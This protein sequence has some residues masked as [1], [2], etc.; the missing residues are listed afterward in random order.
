MI[1]RGDERIWRQNNCVNDRGMLNA[2]HLKSLFARLVSDAVAELGYGGYAIIGNIFGRGGEG[3]KCT[4]TCEFWRTC[5]GRAGP[6]ISF[7][8]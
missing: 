1:D 3:L 7:Y 4:Y 2:S 6:K 5:D 8:L